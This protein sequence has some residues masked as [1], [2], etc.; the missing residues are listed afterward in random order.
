MVVKDGQMVCV[1]LVANDGKKSRV[2]FLG[3]IKHELLKKTYDARVKIYRPKKSFFFLHFKRL[4]LVIERHQR[5]L[6]LF[7]R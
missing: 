3:S 5:E 6:N 4:H 2:L 7:K 1:E